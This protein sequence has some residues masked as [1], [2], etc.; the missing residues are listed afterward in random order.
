MLGLCNRSDGTHFLGGGD[1]VGVR[2]WR[3]GCDVGIVLESNLVLGGG[4]SSG[5]S[6]LSLSVAG[7]AGLRSSFV[8]VGWLGWLGWLSGAVAF[9]S[10]A[11]LVQKGIVSR[12]SH[13]VVAAG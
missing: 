5:S 7:T 9:W 3:A 11:I 2:L 13:E 10:T 1:G 4:I 8:D 6:G 12:C